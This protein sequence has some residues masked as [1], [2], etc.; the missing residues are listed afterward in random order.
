MT[1]FVNVENP[2][3][4]TFRL[5]VMSLQTGEVYYEA[6]PII[7]ALGYPDAEKVF[8]QLCS[9]GIHLQVNDEYIS[10]IPDSDVRRLVSHSS[11]SDARHFSQW[12]LKDARRSALNQMRKLNRF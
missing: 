3:Y 11:E 8:E 12:L 7:K 1:V 10:V 4:G 9:S 6:K 5:A 2:P